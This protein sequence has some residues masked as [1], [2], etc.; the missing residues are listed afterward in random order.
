MPAQQTAT[1]IRRYFKIG[2]RTRR[3]RDGRDLHADI[4]EAIRN[5]SNY[6][7][8]YSE[9]TAQALLPATPVMHA[10]DKFVECGR[11]P[12][13]QIYELKSLSPWK[14]TAL[15]E[16]MI[17]DGITNNGEA[18]RWFKGLRDAS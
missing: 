6:P 8:Y 1:E 12:G 4:F 15:I 7:G 10:W 2:T 16:R 14:L 5:E 11:L 18:E 9:R 17:A 3:Y 13:E